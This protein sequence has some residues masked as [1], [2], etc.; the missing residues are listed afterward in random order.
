MLLILDEAW[1]FL[2]EPFF[3][4]RIRQWLKTLRKKRQRHL[5]Y[6]ITGDNIFMP[7]IWLA[8]GFL[9]LALAVG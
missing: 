5:R 8:Q 9:P 1:L 2:D 4:A 3:A 6:A 7:A